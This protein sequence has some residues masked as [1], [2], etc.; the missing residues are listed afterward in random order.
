MMRY[1]SWKLAVFNM[2]ATICLAG[3]NQ[4]DASPFYGYNVALNN[5]CIMLAVSFG[6]T[7]MA[8]VSGRLLFVAF[9]IFIIFF[10]N[11]I[12]DADAHISLSL[13]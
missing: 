4:K 7:L 11:P 8:M 9:K 5:G 3:L 12:T 2:H 6:C 1:V 10:L 13:I